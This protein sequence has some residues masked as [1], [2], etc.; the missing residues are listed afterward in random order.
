MSVCLLSDT[1]TCGD[2]GFVGSELFMLAEMQIELRLFL[3]DDL[4]DVDI[5]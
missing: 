3:F 4:L 5:C 2:A 1:L